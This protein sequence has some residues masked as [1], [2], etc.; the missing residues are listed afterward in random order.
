M[1]DYDRVFNE[2]IK[3]RGFF[4]QTADIYGGVKGF[5]DYGHLGTLI[6]RNWES[7]WLK[8]FLGLGDN[9]YMIESCNILPE[10]VLKASGH[11][12][13]F[14]DVLVE[15]SKCKETYRGDH[16]IEE[17]IELKEEL[18]D[19][20][21]IFKYIQD[22]GIVCKNCGGALRKPRNFNMM[23]PIDIGA[24]SK[25]KGYLR[26]ETAQGSYLNFY[27]E[28]EALRRKIPMGL[29]IIGKAFRNEISPRQGFFRV[30]E[31]TQ[32]ELQIFHDP[33]TFNDIFDFESVKD[34]KINICLVKERD[35]GDFQSYTCEEIRKI[36][37]LPE[38]YIY[39]M[40][41][42]QQ[43]YFDILQLPT[44]KVRFFEK[45]EK[46]RA[47]YNKI[48]FDIEV[49]LRQLKSFKEVAG[50]H[51]RGDYDLSCHQKGSKKKLSI[52][53]KDGRKI[54]LSV[55]EL[56]F[57]V[58]RNILA[59]IDS[60]FYIKD[61]RN[62][63]RLPPRVAPYHIGV[64]PLQRRDNLDKKAKEIYQ[65]LK[66]KFR[67][68]YDETGSIGKRY[69]RLD[70]IGVP[71]CITVDYETLDNKDPNFD[72]VTIR[73][74]DSKDQIRVKIMELENWLYENINK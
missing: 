21:E 46:E 57:G 3:K 22:L 15:C 66:L 18:T 11:V 5:Y 73:F 28:F 69:A 70:E 23:F 67:A 34:Y 53:M 61:N 27:R 51:Y 14:T 32:A 52:K 10:A 26:P 24:T 31:F 16:L 38:F 49:N 55:L 25:D 64:F 63:L 54:L 48:H 59:L 2:F 72:T 7:E 33:K 43:F 44:D 37:D 41:K 39:H 47:F 40:A 36:T 30:R 13:H 4:W 45:S 65:N 17:K 19:L 71:Y 35:R 74:R 50:L 56:S 29:A 20:D 60:N 42:T 9:Y 62:I 1:N 8:Y 12:D 68:F 6:K 58:D